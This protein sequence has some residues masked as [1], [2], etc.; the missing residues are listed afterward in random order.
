MLMLLPGGLV[1]LAV[2]TASVAPSVALVGLELV[3]RR[4]ADVITDV[5]LEAW[6]VPVAE[7][8]GADEVRIVATAEVTEPAHLL[9][10]DHRLDATVREKLRGSGFGSCL[11]LP[12][13]FGGDVLGHLEV[14]AHEQRPASRFQIGGRDGSAPN[15]ASSCMAGRPRDGRR[16]ADLEGGALR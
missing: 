14:Y 11:I 4:L 10:D 12:I 3:A 1:P 15:S 7:E 8:L 13:A 2:L 5:E 16:L 6:L 9:A